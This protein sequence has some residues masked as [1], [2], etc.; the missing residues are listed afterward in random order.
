MSKK[1]EWDK[2]EVPRDIEIL[3]SDYEPTQ[4]EMNEVFSVNAT[5]EALAKAVMRSVNVQ[6][7]SV[8]EHKSSR[9][10]KS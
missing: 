9:S 6:R 10:K 7:K 3:P 8:S 1:D 2:K 5:P 4:A